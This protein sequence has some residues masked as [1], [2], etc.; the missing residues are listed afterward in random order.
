MDETQKRGIA[1]RLRALDQ[2][3]P[4]TQ[5]EVAAKL[6]ITKRGYQK[7]LEKG[8]TKRRRCHEM[9]K[10]HKTW[11]TRSS[12]WQHVSEDWIV[13]GRMAQEETPDLMGTAD[14]TELRQ[15]LGE[16]RAMRSILRTEAAKNAELRT[17]LERLAKSLRRRASEG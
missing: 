3:S 13:D 5:D 12:A 16:L 8:T 17:E 11:T 10:I 7:M 6:G 1:K 14:S 4:W 9:W 15:L 2:A